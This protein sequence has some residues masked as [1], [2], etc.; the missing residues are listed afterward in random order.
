MRL[1]FITLI[2]CMLIS[3]SRND[4]DDSIIDNSAIEEPIVDNN[5]GFHRIDVKLDYDTPPVW[6][7]TAEFEE[8]KGGQVYEDKFNSNRWYP[9]DTIWHAYTNNNFEKSMGKYYCKEFVGGKFRSNNSSRELT[10][11]LNFFPTFREVC[12]PIKVKITGYINEKQSCDTAFTIRPSYPDYDLKQYVYLKTI[13]DV[14]TLDGIVVNE[15]KQ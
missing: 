14:S 2:S 6:T 3:C 11:H 9:V 5:I 12:K 1:F 15:E 8:S 7:M 4:I 10:L 13:I